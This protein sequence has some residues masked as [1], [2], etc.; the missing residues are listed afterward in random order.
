M[1][2]A[3]LF[4]P[5]PDRDASS[6]GRHAA[7]ETGDDERTVAVLDATPGRHAAPDADSGDDDVDADGDVDED[8]DLLDALGFDYDED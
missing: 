3:S 2:L 8:E 1:T 6:G 4:R 7:P 5:A